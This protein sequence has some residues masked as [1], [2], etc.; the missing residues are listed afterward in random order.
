MS[1][2]RMPLR[3]IVVGLA[4]AALLIVALALVVVAQDP[5]GR[6]TSVVQEP[7]DRDASIPPDQVTVVEEV[8]LLPD[9][10]A[11]DATLYFKFISA[12]TFVPYDDD[13]TYVYSS[14][15][16][17]SRTGGGNYTEHTL[18]LPE[19]AEIDYLRVYFWDNDATH[20]AT[21]YLFAYD[22]KGG[23]TSI[24]YASSSGQAGSYRSEGSGYFSHIVD[25]LNEAL[26][27]SLYYGGATTSD[28]KICGVRVRYQYTISLV[29]L[30]LILNG[31]S[32]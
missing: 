9:P 28:L 5:D 24:A 32:P 23:S 26:S 14:G 27:L 8:E 4:L 30:P 16:C 3:N 2:P 6:D 25:N 22:G 7:G 21:A 31:T 12:N 10:S 18:Q 15:G 17:M 1:H 11:T 13:M 20:D 19:G 29:D